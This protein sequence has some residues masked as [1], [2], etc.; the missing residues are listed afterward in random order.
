MSEKLKPC[1]LCKEA[2]TYMA[3]LATEIP[4]ETDYKIDMVKLISDIRRNSKSILSLM[5]KTSLQWRYDD[6]SPYTNY[7]RKCE[8]AE[9]SRI[10]RETVDAV[11]DLLE[12]RA[13]HLNR[14]AIECKQSPEQGYDPKSHIACSLALT[15]LIPQVRAIAEEPQDLDSEA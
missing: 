9:K 2:Y 15:G 4:G 14:A 11:I 10:R 1:P 12:T 6:N 3:Y 5:D 7:I 8:E 13:E